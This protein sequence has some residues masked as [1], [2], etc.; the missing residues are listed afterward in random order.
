MDKDKFK[1]GDRVVAVG[2]VD[3]LKLNGKKGTVVHISSN[4]SINIGVEFLT[5]F[6]GGHSCRGNGKDGYCRY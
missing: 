6:V 4:T 3:T 5:S 2:E 1:V